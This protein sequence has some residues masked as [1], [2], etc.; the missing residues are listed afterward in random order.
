MDTHRAAHHKETLQERQQRHAFERLTYL[1][2]GV[3][4]IAVTL[5]AL[6]LKPEGFKGGDWEAL[7]A[8]LAPKLAAYVI[9]FFVIATFW[10]NTRRNF[11]RLERVDG[12]VA[13]LTMTFLG[14]VALIPASSSMMYTIPGMGPQTIYLALIALISAVQALAWGYAAFIARLV[15]PEVGVAAKIYIFLTGLLAP[16]TFAGL[17]FFAMRSSGNTST[18]AWVGMWSM[19][20]VLSFLSRRLLKG[21]R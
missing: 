15:A 19:V 13:W 9:S 7:L 11:S 3:F 12:P 6:D 1:V 20:F 17:S 16:T 2:D 4:A 14:L 10:F 18:M 5:L 8:N 21:L